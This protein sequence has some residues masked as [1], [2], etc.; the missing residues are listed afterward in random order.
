MTGNVDSVGGCSLLSE[1]SL[2]MA[3][4]LSHFSCYIFITI[5]VTLWCAIRSFVIQVVN[6][7]YGPGVLKRLTLT[8]AM[9]CIL[10]N[11]RPFCLQLV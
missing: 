10:V 11:S 2:A 3:M 5:A 9:R 6:D 4:Q 7:H 1:T 8:I